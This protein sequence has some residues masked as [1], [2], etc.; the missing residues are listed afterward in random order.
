VNYIV[1]RIPEYRAVAAANAAPGPLYSSMIN[2]AYYVDG[3]FMGDWYG[4]GRYKQFT[5]HLDNADA[6]YDALHRLGAVYFLVDLPHTF[7]P[8]LPY[9]EQFDAHFEPVYADSVAELSSSPGK[10]R[11]ARFGTAKPPGEWRL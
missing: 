5:D 6:L 10:P 8:P 1:A 4:P 11:A 7:E 2:V 9:G 3:L